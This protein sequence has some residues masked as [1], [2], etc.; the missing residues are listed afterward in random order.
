[1]LYLSGL[2]LSLASI[3]PCLSA[4]GFFL[5]KGFVLRALCYRLEWQVEFVPGLYLASAFAF[6]VVPAVVGAARFASDFELVSAVVVGE[7]HH[8]DCYPIALV[9]VAVVGE[10]VQVLAAG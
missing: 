6:E 9:L 10:L 7:C 8:L 5:L 1:M 3:V 4:S 2:A